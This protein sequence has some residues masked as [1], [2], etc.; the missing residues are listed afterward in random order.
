MRSVRQ[1][2]A[3]APAPSPAA[4]RWAQ[5]TVIDQLLAGGDRALRALALAVGDNGPLTRAEITLLQR[6]VAAEA[7]R[8]EPLARTPRETRRALS[9]ACARQAASNAAVRAHHARQGAVV[10]ATP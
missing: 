7:G 8:G 4:T 3:P 2:L 9:A 10:F 1:F 5:E 6:L